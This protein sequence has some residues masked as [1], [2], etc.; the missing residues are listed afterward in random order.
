MRACDLDPMTKA[1][2]VK[3][4][5]AQMDPGMYSRAIEQL[6]EDGLIDF[7]LQG[8]EREATKPAKQTDNCSW[9]GGVVA[10]VIA[11]FA[12]AAWYALPETVRVVF[13]VIIWVSYLGYYMVIPALIW[14]AEWGA[15]YTRPFR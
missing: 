6:G 14:V 10:V 4:I 11:G 2:L 7:V 15:R 1:N 12:A 13:E 3:Q 5:E 9:F 8:A